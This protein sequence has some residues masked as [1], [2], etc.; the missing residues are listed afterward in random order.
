MLLREAVLS[1]QPSKISADQ[2]AHV[3]AGK[4]RRYTL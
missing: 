3:H 4:L 2:L 1:P